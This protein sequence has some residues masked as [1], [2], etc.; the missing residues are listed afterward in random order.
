MRMRSLVAIGAG[1][2]AVSRNKNMRKQLQ[3][4]M[5]PIVSSIEGIIPKGRTIKRFRKQMMKI[6]S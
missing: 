1:A 5:T 6:I 2:Y 4:R 3:K